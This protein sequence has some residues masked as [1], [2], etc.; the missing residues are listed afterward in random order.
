MRII[1]KTL[2]ILKMV[3]IFFC[4]KKMKNKNFDKKIKI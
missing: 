3:N 2:F 4:E 1:I